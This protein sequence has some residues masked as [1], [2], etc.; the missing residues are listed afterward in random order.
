MRLAKIYLSLIVSCFFTSVC[1]AQNTT[2]Q[3]P[4]PPPGA[5]A[6]EAEKWNKKQQTAYEKSQERIRKEEKKHPNSIIGGVYNPNEN[7]SS[8]SNN[9]NV[10]QKSDFVITN[11]SGEKLYQKS[12]FVTGMTPEKVALFFDDYV[13]KTIKFSVWLGTIEATE[14]STGKAFGISVRTEDGEYFLPRIYQKRVKSLNFVLSEDMAR[15]TMEAQEELSNT[16]DGRANSTTSRGAYIYTEI[17]QIGDYN[18]ANILCIEFIGR[19]AKNGVV[20]NIAIKS[21]G[22]Q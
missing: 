12:D 15:K 1:L 9:S 4:P 5:S 18:L 10:G 22:C 8:Q 14:D 20:S 3:P 13:G 21:I 11:I 7:N 17:K 2:A 6:K 19:Q 16:V